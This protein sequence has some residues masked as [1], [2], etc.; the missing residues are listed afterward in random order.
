MNPSTASAISGS[1]RQ[2]LA[3]TGASGI[4][5]KSLAG[6]APPA[7]VEFAS[8]ALWLN[9]CGLKALATPAQTYRAPPAGLVPLLRSDGALYLKTEADYRKLI[10]SW[11]PRPPAPGGDGWLAAPPASIREV[12]LASHE[13]KFAGQINPAPN[14]FLLSK[15]VTPCYDPRLLHIQIDPIHPLAS[16]LSG[17]APAPDSLIGTTEAA[18]IRP[19]NPARWRIPRHHELWNLIREILRQTFLSGHD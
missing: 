17:Y 8:L 13:I 4:N 2:V 9:L 16:L 18:A 3:T 11:M 5:L 19:S 10:L 7:Q 1:L 14:G 6:S 12:V 15:C